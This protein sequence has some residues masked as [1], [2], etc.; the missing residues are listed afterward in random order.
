[1][2]SLAKLLRIMQGIGKK[3]KNIGLEIISVIHC[4]CDNHDKLDKRIGKII[5]KR[6]K[7]TINRDVL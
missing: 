3:Y 6:G 4:I 7:N 2:V 1:M 5:M